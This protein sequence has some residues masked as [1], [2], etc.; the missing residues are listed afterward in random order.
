[1]TPRSP[2]LA[3]EDLAVQVRATKKVRHIRD[4]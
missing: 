2:A 4:M 1:M 3:S